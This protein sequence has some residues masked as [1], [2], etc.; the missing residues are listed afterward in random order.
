M[1][2]GRREA[3][4]LLLGGDPQYTGTLFGGRTG[5][6]RAVVI[7]GSGVPLLGGNGG[8]LFD[9]RLAADHGTPSAPKLCCSAGRSALNGAAPPQSASV[10]IPRA[11]EERLRILEFVRVR[12]DVFDLVS[13]FVDLPNLR[14]YALTESFHR[15]HFQVLPSMLDFP[16]VAAIH[17]DTVRQSLLRKPEP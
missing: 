11:L 4:R 3:G 6:P 12:F 9:S 2:W 8:R 14:S 1:H 17:P 13:V 5:Q 10:G 16:V 7:G 15:I